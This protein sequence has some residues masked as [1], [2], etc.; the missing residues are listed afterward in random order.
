MI[1]AAFDYHR[2]ASV[3]E[4][5][6]LL[7]D[8]AKLLAG[9]H[10][11]LPAMKLRLSTPGALID[12]GRLAELNY[13]K[14]DGGAIAIGATTTHYQ[15]ES[16]DLVQSK[17]SALALAASA[18]GDP[19]VRN[20][21]TIGGSIAH[22]DPAA[23]Y[24]AA[25]LALGAEITVKGPGGERTISADEFFVDLFMTALADDE[26]I[27]EIR[28]SAADKSSYA[29]FPHP[30]SR[31]AVVGC[32]AASSGGAVRVAFTGVAN[33]AFRDT[34]VE[35]ALGGNLSEDSIGAAAEK[36]A[37]GAEVLSDNFAGEDYRRHLAKVFARKALSAIA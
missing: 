34:G 11:L 4:A 8:D 22:A 29:K 23:D 28:V 5:I 26:I 3:D 7:S 17:A 36:A 19:L 33:A 21:G 16:S 14:E 2:P 25:I 13:I 31:F 30:A 15:I 9:G 18:I 27:T 6:Q 1:P 10:S 12:I 20:K 35:E 32:A 37:D 24:P